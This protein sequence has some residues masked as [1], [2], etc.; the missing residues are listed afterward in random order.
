MAPVSPC[1]PP[2]RRSTMFGHPPLDPP[3][4]T[5]GYRNNKLMS[6]GNGNSNSSNGNMILSS[7][8]ATVPPSPGFP[9]SNV[10]VP[11]F[12]TPTMNGFETPTMNGFKTPTM[13][14]FKTSTMN[15]FETPTMNGFKT[16]TMKAAPVPAHPKFNSKSGN[17]GANT[18]AGIKKQQAK[19]QQTKKIVASDKAL[20]KPFRFMDLPG[21][22]RNAIYMHTHTQRRQALLV[23]RPRLATLRSRTRVDRGRT[24]ASDIAEKKQDEE[25]STT[26]TRRSAGSHSTG[27]KP[28]LIPRGTNRPFWGLTQVCQQIRQ[29]FR[30]IYLKKQEIGMDLTQ[31]VDYLQTFYP[32]APEETAKLAPPGERTGDMPFHGNLTIAVG[33]KPNNL[34]Q[35]TEGI[36]VFPLLDIWA[37]S[38]K[39]EAG[40]GRY[41]KV[42]YVP[43][44]DGE[45]KDLY[46]LF[47]RRVL[48]NRTCS[49]MNSMWR[50]ILRNHV[51]E[52]VCVHRKPAPPAAA[53]PGSGGLLVARYFHAAAAP[54]G[55]MVPAT[56]TKPYMHIIFKKECAEP[57]MT[58]FESVIPK[59]WLAERGFSG[60]EHFD[61]RVGV[62]KGGEK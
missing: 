15:G 25:L 29:E 51:L 48:R 16:P 4:S 2:P 23:Y 31:I 7:E 17:K 20:E 42:N 54:P 9:L 27:P 28:T 36:D 60:M 8:H 19:K 62:E 46:R 35:A 26:M 40:F 57:W 34:E 38:F 22:I 41:L 1:N 10:P 56:V 59:D 44:T 30:P 52:S 45:A 11:G 21:E 18:G 14:G 58:Q 13:N 47:G 5:P 49:A 53:G 43:E 39:I 37:N 24:L 33:D 61:V 6:N 12:E 50:T 32:S 3:P 55:P